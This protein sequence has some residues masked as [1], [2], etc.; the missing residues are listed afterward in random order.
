[1]LN[2]QF[3]SFLSFSGLVTLG[4]T[5][6]SRFEQFGSML[7]CVSILIK[8]NCFFEMSGDFGGP[9]YAEPY[10]DEVLSIVKRLMADS[11][12]DESLAFNSLKETSRDESVRTRTRDTAHAMS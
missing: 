6:A 11:D 8:E 7:T 5:V 10:G 3:S 9:R 2:F 4:S 1:M 12:E